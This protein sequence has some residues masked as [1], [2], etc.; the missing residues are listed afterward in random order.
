M[1]R[2]RADWHP[3]RGGPNRAAVVEGG[4]GDGPPAPELSWVHADPTGPGRRVSVVGRRPRIVGADV[5]Y[6]LGDDARGIAFD[7]ACDGAGVDADVNT[8]IAR[9]RHP[10][11]RR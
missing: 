1:R 3:L 7:R 5:I 9:M 2:V 4:A 6:D 11:P 10:K 8:G